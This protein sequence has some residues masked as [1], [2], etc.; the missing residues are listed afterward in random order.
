MKTRLI[1]VLVGLLAWAALPLSPDALHA[2]SGAAP[3]VLF[4]NGGLWT[5]NEGEAAPTPL[6]PSN[7]SSPALSPDG[8]RIA[9]LAFS[10]ITLEAI[11]ATGG[12]GGGALPSDIVIV[13]I[14]TGRSAAIATQPEDASFFTEG[15][16]DSALMRSAPVWSPDGQQVAWTELHYPSLARDTNRLM[17]YDLAQGTQREVITNLPD[18]G[19]VPG[20]IPV[21]WG[22]S[23]F[24]LHSYEF[25]PADSTFSLSLLFYDTE[26]RLLSQAAFPDQTGPVLSETFWID[27]NGQE[28]L[29]LYYHDGTF[30]LLNPLTGQ[31][32]PLNGQPELY[33]SLAPDRL[34]LTFSRD[35]AQSYFASFTWYAVYPDGA[36]QIVA[37]EQGYVNNVAISPA[38]NAVAY[39]AEDYQLIVWRDG[40]PAAYSFP[41]V[42]WWNGLLWAPAAW[43][44][45]SV[46]PPESVSCPGAPQPRLMIGDTGRVLPGPP[47]NLRDQPGSGTVIGQIASG[48]SFTVLDGPR[49][50]NEMNWWQVD[51]NGTVGWTAEGD[52]SAYWLEPLG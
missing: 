47:N 9:Y 49:C 51:A 48:D 19:G 23:A 40:T 34:A 18:Q 2:Q 43:R 25:N 15:R 21:A 4:M 3:L 52:A 1:L 6:V 24:V 31:T 41:E 38:G 20:P 35:P 12:I 16:E 46:Q 14:Q 45:G 13:D 44:V 30:E 37:S 10:P 50:V 26:G 5:W 22:R 29:A 11:E 28:F 17:V 8:Q 39:L 7:V 33:S 36:T 32:Q 42:E 27:Q